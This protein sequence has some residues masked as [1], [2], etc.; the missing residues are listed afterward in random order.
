MKKHVVSAIDNLTNEDNCGQ[1]EANPNWNYIA[2]RLADSSTSIYG[3][4]LTHSATGTVGQFVTTVPNSASSGTWQALVNFNGINSI[5]FFWVNCPSTQNAVWMG[6]VVDG[7]LLFLKVLSKLSM[8][9]KVQSGI[10]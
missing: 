2:L 3:H 10:Q 8:S 9:T 6:M 1:P 5:Y 7:Y 4:I